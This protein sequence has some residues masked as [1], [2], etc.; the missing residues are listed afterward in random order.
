MA[1]YNINTF[2]PSR[3]DRATGYASGCAG[4][5]LWLLNGI[6]LACKIIGEEVRRLGLSSA[7]GSAGTVNVQG[8]EQQGLDVF[9]NKVLMDCLG[10]RGNVGLLASEEN[11]E[12]MVMIEHPEQGEYIVIFDP[13]DGSSN[14]DVNVSVGTIFS[15]YRRTKDQASSWPTKCCNRAELK[16]RPA[17]RSTDRRPCWS[18]PRAT[19]FLVL[20]SIQ[21]SARSC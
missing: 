9:A 3:D 19:A 21:P 7:A 14:L 11:E 17:M 15:I 20:R 8:E 16:L 12:P 6:E 4:Q 2:A 18:T 13:L 5:F 1:E 10:S